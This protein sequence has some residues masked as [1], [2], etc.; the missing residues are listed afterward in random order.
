LGAWTV[1][2]GYPNH[3]GAGHDRAERRRRDRTSVA[4]PYDRLGFPGGLDHDLAAGN[5]RRRLRA[6]PSLDA[7]TARELDDQPGS[8]GHG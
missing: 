3:H 7:A 1:T 6:Q 4:I 5:A 8:L 2:G